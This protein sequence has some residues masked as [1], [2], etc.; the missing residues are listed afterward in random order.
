MRGVSRDMDW[1]GEPLGVDDAA[2]I[3]IAAEGEV[4]RRRVPV[5][6]ISTGIVIGRV[7]EAICR[8]RRTHA[9][10]CHDAARR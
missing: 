9:T 6:L 4:T 2:I 5:V 7:A 1:R 10:R 3:D 8:L